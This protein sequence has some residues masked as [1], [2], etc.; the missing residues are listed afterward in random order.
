MLWLDHM[1]RLAQK[2]TWGNREVHAGLQLP[3]AW[4]SRF[5]I[6]GPIHAHTAMVMVWLCQ[7]CLKF[8]DIALGLT[9]RLAATNQQHQSRG[10]S[11]TTTLD[12][13]GKASHW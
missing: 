11:C 10:P 9:L 7:S 8:D 6:Q 2:L 5:D 4:K 3:G 13:I 12:I 1:M